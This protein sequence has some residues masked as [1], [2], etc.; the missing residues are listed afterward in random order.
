MMK[1]TVFPSPL[2]WWEG[3]TLVSLTLSLPV[4][5]YSQLKTCLP[6][7]SASVEDTDVGL[8]F[9]AMVTIHQ[10]KP[11]LNICKG[12]SNTNKLSQTSLS[13]PANSVSPQ[14]KPQ[15]PNRNART[16]KTTVNAKR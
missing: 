14:Q 4:L 5:L 3:L 7:I 2:S 12:D 8:Q 13:S 16:L 1:I 11:F 10:I 6:I 9:K 15:T